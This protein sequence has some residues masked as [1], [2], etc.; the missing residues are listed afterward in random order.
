M[1]KNQFA[2]WNFFKYSIKR[3]P[4]N[5]STQ[6]SESSQTGALVSA[7]RSPVDGLISPLLHDSSH[8]RIM[9]AG[10]AMVRDFLKVYINIDPTAPSDMVVYG[11]EDPC[12]RY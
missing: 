11:Y 1:Y 4:R 9:Q 3:R 10:L 7:S 6:E 8:T 2:R 5:K 12:F